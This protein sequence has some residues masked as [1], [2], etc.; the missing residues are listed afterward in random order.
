MLANAEPFKGHLG[1]FPGQRWM[2]VV[3]VSGAV[4][5]GHL[6]REGSL[7][8]LIVKYFAYSRLCIFNF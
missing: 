8:V 1:Y 5:S 7:G 4:S 6:G 2:G 3:G